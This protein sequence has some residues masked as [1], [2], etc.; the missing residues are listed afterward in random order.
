M[1]SIEKYLQD[2]NITMKELCQKYSVF[3]FTFTDIMKGN[4]MVQIRDLMMVAEILDCDLVEL[5]KEFYDEKY[6]K[7]NQKMNTKKH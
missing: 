6:V 1:N 5:F 2:N 4:R 7:K 3:T